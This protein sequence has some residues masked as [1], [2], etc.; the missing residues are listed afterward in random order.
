MELHGWQ[1]TGIDFVP[2]AIRTAR[3]KA[4][5]AGLSID[6]YVADVT[7]LS[8]ITGPYDYILDIGCLFTLNAEGQ[9]KY[10]KNLVTRKGQHPE[11]CEW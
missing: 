3:Q 2:K 1:A 8:F 5:A 11:I 10:A 7:D 6:F 4:I 9:E